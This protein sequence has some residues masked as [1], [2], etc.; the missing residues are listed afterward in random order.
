[1]AAS[2]FARTIVIGGGPIDVELSRY[3]DD[4]F[5]DIVFRHE[6]RTIRLQCKHSDARVE[7]AEERFTGGDTRLK[8]EDLVQGFLFDPTDTTELRLYASWQ[9]P[10][11]AER[12]GFLLP[13][14]RPAFHA[15][16]SSSRWRLDVEGIWPSAGAPRWPTLKQFA[17][18]SFRRFAE[19]FVLELETPAMSGELAN[20][21]TLENLLGSILV[22]ELAVERPP[23]ERDA[24]D[25]AA[26]LI[27]LANSARSRRD[28]ERTF[29]ADD[30]V[31]E[32]GL[33][34]DRGRLTQAS[35]LVASQYV[36]SA[37]VPLLENAIGA[38]SRVV[39]T[40]APGSGKSWTL[41]ALGR[42]LK[43]RGYVVARHYCFLEPGDPD[44]QRRVS[45]EAL[46]ANLISG[47]VA[48]R[49]L[50]RLQLGLAGD[51]TALSA[52]VS[53]AHK[54][55]YEGDQ[56]DG[57]PPGIVLIVD[58]I[59]HVSRVERVGLPAVRP[60]DIVVS[61]N[62]LDL[63]DRVTL[64]VGSQPG[65]FLEPL[66]G[67]ATSEFKTRAFTRAQ[68]AVQ[69]RSLG[70]FSALRES[71]LKE[72]QRDV[73]DAIVARS[74]GN[75]LYA[76][77]IARM[78]LAWIVSPSAET[79]GDAIRN[80]PA[81]GDDL[82]RYYEYLLAGAE[83]APDAG[84]VAEHLAM[85][86]FSATLDD[87]AEMLPALGKRRLDAALSHLRPILIE[88]TA[89]GSR[90]YHES[91]R[92]YV[93]A[94]LHAEGRSVSALLEPTI[95][96]LR[97]KGLFADARSYRFLLPF[98]RRASRDAE[99]L[100]LVNE[101]F[102]AR[103]VV[104]LHPESAAKANIALAAEVAGSCEDFPKLAALAQ[105]S[106][107]RWVTYH[108][109][110]DDLESYARA[111]IELHGPKYVA[112]R[113]L[114]DGRPVFDADDG[115]RIC[116][117][118]DEAG[119]VAPWRPYLRSRRSS[120]RS[121][122]RV[123][124]AAFLGACRLDS[125]RA[126]EDLGGWLATVQEPSRELI[127]GIAKVVTRVF[128]LDRVAAFLESLSS[129]VPLQTKAW[130]SLALG[131]ARMVA[132]DTT[133]ALASARQALEQGLV[134][135][136][137]PDAVACG[138]PRREVQACAPKLKA[139]LAPLH[140]DYMYPDKDSV[141]A[142]VAVAALNN[143]KRAASSAR[144]EIEEYGWYRAWLRFVLDISIARDD[145]AVLRALRELVRHADR[146]SGS[147]RACDLSSIGEVVTET[148]SRAFAVL[149]PN[150]RVEALECLLTIT[151]ETTSYLEGEPC[152]PFR[153]WELAECLL[154]HAEAGLVQRFD[155]FVTT[156]WNNEYYENHAELCLQLARLWKRVGDEELSSLRWRDAGRYLAAYGSHKDASI[157]DVIYGIRVL[158]DRVAKPEVVAELINLQEL[159][160]RCL[161]H[162][163]GKETNAAP[164]EWFR[165]LAHV[166]PVAAMQLL[167][168][169]MLSDDRV[170]YYRHERAFSAVIAE[171]PS[172]CSPLL[173]TLI[174][175]IGPAVGHA[176]DRLRGIA[177]LLKDDQT[178]GNEMFRE[179]LVAVEGDRERRRGD[180]SGRGSVAEFAAAQGLAEV[181]YPK[182][183]SVQ[184]HYKPRREAQA[185][186]R[187]PFFPNSPTALQLLSVLRAARLDHYD[188]RAD[189]AA[190]AAELGPH[191][192]SLRAKDGNAIVLSLCEDFARRL[193]V[194]RATVL[195][196]L[197]ARFEALDPGLAAELYMLAWCASRLSWP[198]L[199][200][201]RH[202]DL[203]E[204]AF[205][206]DRKQALKRLAREMGGGAGDSFRI[207]EA[208]CIAGAGNDAL[209]ALRSASSVIAYRLPKTGDEFS[210]FLPLAPVGVAS[211][212]A[213]GELTA[214][215]LT[216]TDYER[217]GLALA[218]LAQLSE[219]EPDVLLSAAATL[220]TSDATLG[221]ELMIMALLESLARAGSK[222]ALEGM[223]DRLM[224]VARST[225]FALSAMAC[226]LLAHVGIDLDAA[227]FFSTPSHAP[228]A[229]WETRL[230]VSG[231]KRIARVVASHAAFPDLVA[232]TYDAILS[233]RGRRILTEQRAK[234]TARGASWVPRF[235]L[236]TWD[237]ELCLVA[238]DANLGVVVGELDKQGRWTDAIQQEFLK[239]VVPDAACAAARARSR[240]LRPD[241]RLP[242]D[243]TSEL[244]APQ[245]ERA[246]R[247]EGWVQ[248]GLWERQFGD[249]WNGP[250]VGFEAT[251]RS[252][253]RCKGASIT[254]ATWHPAS[255]GV[256]WHEQEGT[257]MDDF[258]G[259]VLTQEWLQ[260]DAA[261]SGR[262]LTLRPEIRGLLELRPRRLPS[263][264]DL[265]DSS[266]RA[267]AVYRFW[268]YQP[269]S[270]DYG[271]RTPTL[272]GGV[273]LVDP[274]AS[275]RVQKVVGELEAVT[276]VEQRQLG[277]RRISG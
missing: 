256:F 228:H 198:G 177:A 165:V 164:D 217:R 11:D 206:I 267:L 104:A 183:P 56:G 75:P 83:G 128:D 5:D 277:E 252:G 216:H 213:C 125:A 111:A 25:V 246:G 114:F 187:G 134:T 108:E 239:A 30:L 61:L 21:G 151:T 250:S 107:A 118:L 178:L 50:A 27:E 148:I 31:R 34:T 241:I 10:A 57:S 162:S 9:P 130:F 147:P 46:C 80:L 22:D 173:Q 4:R 117:L 243:R 51:F 231:D 261:F 38:S 122:V 127:W 158:A 69:A 115:L 142:F 32:L 133:G 171:G 113:L 145:E 99:I 93:L 149:S 39:L 79:P 48:D 1:M 103:S 192:E 49:R 168:R 258:G 96:W 174:A 129:E 36:K 123:E 13:S 169:S 251:V 24:V 20:P 195:E 184:E 94:R 263:A 71:S 67:A 238:A 19:Q 223:V 199:E 28:A 233:R 18:E 109:K 265:V 78:L 139:A 131:S 89:G 266:G 40:G 196:Q 81:A 176:E 254:S 186:N 207:V 249:D 105:L 179:C 87:L 95:N 98:L 235:A 225:S 203:L 116:A 257:T 240:V 201:P 136:R 274:E 138:V 188:L 62:A 224:E 102:V 221:D 155:R 23:N 194:E 15:N 180:D 260:D 52:A 137:L 268:R 197:G 152:G 218:T 17:R 110:L 185:L 37:T 124:L 259:G 222:A 73:L 77:F 144:D 86:E 100:A 226:H 234:Q 271:P 135:E 7:L 242:R 264:M 211:S 85:L 55:L 262:A 106:H 245:C 14:A 273:L 59:D 210:S 237:R 74:A 92:R 212:Q 121:D 272:E 170:P 132:G 215:M 60:E 157:F 63:P 119:G 209:A 270:L 42:R 41:E 91:L 190:F 120:G 163:D 232:R 112:D 205:R 181:S 146:F 53:S 84:F 193:F 65:E 90:I 156:E 97:T 276:V 45:V 182:E 214:A 202:W 82:A 101:D 141:R 12:V 54:H 161:A 47:L 58:G 140:S 204:Q 2:A 227:R 64:V 68:L 175:R 219:L 248:Y 275:A 166:D 8:I 6:A 70:V 44:V 244:G 167:S 229:T 220:M 247:Y 189:H 16:T 33:I 88:Q 153:L 200:R 26:R 160:E 43:A 3:A 208:L 159:A 150:A 191:L 29:S 66:R 126:L 143:N 172:C 76:R 269:Y 255:T 253:V 72:H 236:H 230:L 35:P 154:L